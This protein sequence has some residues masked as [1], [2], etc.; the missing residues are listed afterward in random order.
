MNNKKYSPRLPHVLTA[1]C[2]TAG[3]LLTI[4]QFVWWRVQEWEKNSELLERK[5]LERSRFAREN[6]KLVMQVNE[7]SRRRNHEIKHHMQTLYSLLMAQEA[8]EAKRYIEKVIEEENQYAEMIY[9]ENIVLNSIVGMRLNQAKENAIRVQCHIHVP[10]RLEADDV[11]LSILLS[12]MLENALEACQRMEDRKEAYII[13]EIRKNQKFLFIECENS[14][15]VKEILKEGQTTIKE[16]QKNHG[17]GLDA[18]RT[19]A[20]KYAGIIQTVREPGSFTVRT[21]LCLPE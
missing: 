14:V 20:E 11:D 6:Y 7:D 15:D 13:L 8:D 5:L 10:C 1:V 12:N 21:N 16:D 3:T 9:S 18:M 17:F 4:A 19:V 2:L